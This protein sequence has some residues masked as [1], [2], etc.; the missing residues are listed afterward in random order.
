MLAGIKDNFGGDQRYP[1]TYMK[2]KGLLYYFCINITMEFNS[3]DVRMEGL[4]VTLCEALT[5]KT[6]TETKGKKRNLISP[7]RTIETPK[8][9]T[10]KVGDYF[11]II[12]SC[13]SVYYIKCLFAIDSDLHVDSPF[14][15]LNQRRLLTLTSARPSPKATN[16]P[17]IP[18]RGR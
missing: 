7:H 6:F 2:P 18:R 17:P 5:E 12:K 1:E 10:R 8:I 15:R 11:P 3:P 4:D 16:F 9:T 13:I 14:A